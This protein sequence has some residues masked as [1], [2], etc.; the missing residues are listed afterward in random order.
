[1]AATLKQI[2][3]L[4]GVSRGTVDRALYDRGRVAPEVAKRVKKIA[5]DL[6]YQPHRAGRALALA[7]KP[8]KIGVVVQ[9]VDTPFMQQVLQGIRKAKADLEDLG[10]QVFL[11]EIES[12]NTQHLICGIDEMVKKGVGGLAILPTDDD[13][14]RE[15]LNS[16]D[17]PVVTFNSDIDQARRLCFVGLDG[18]RGGR[19]AAGLMNT[20]LCGRGRVLVMTGHV[21][22]RGH[23]Q[24]I[25]GFTDEVGRSFPGIRLLDTQACNDN[26]EMARSITLHMLRQYPDINGMYL[27]ASGVDG[28]CRVLAEMGCKDRVKVIAYD[29][30]EANKRNLQEGYLDFL[31]GQ[32]SYA[33]G[34]RPSMILFDYLFSGKK[35]ESEHLYTDI[36]IKTKYNL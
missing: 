25:S 34:Y 32:D 23:N 24:R 36:V 21:T 12:V 2:A 13:V 28:V 15:K 10:A 8:I 11:R 35:P 22:S 3:E 27:A 31:L 4:A 29:V 14:L 6:N 18:L 7:K 5:A 9:S 30:T 20:L 26:D 17:I 19:T 16:M 1:M 33:Q